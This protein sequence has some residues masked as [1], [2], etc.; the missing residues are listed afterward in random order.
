MVSHHSSRRVGYAGPAQ[1]GPWACLRVW[2]LDRGTGFK[3]WLC[4]HL[5]CELRTASA[6]PNKA[7]VSPCRTRRHTESRPQS[8]LP[9]VGFLKGAEAEGPAPERGEVGSWV[10]SFKPLPF[11][12]PLLFPAQYSELNA[13]R[14]ISSSHITPGRCYYYSLCTNEETKAQRGKKTCLKSHSRRDRARI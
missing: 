11:M 7:S 3:Y 4:H 13:H 5:L 2:A 12:A 14:L 1:L 10:F 6:F 8:G 9:H